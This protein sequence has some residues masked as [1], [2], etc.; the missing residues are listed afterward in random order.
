MSHP[1]KFATIAAQ[2][3]EQTLS[4][5]GQMQDL[6]VQSFEAAVG[7]IPKSPSTIAKAFPTP[8]EVVE[9]SFGFAERLL[10]QQKTYALRLAEVAAK[11]AAKAATA[12]PKE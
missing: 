1:A 5:L 4:T 11:G 2:A 6:S 3:Q 10:E 12:A 9:A 8:A 7:L